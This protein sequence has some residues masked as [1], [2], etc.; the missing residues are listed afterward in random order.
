MSRDSLSQI[1]FPGLRMKFHVQI[2]VQ[3]LQTLQEV[4][5]SPPRRKRSMRSLRFI[6]LD[7]TI[8]LLAE[9]TVVDRTDSGETRA[10]QA[11]FMYLSHQVKIK[12]HFFCNVILNLEFNSISLFSLFFI[13]HVCSSLWYE[14]TSLMTAVL[15]WLPRL[16]WRRLISR[17]AQ[18]PSSSDYSDYQSPC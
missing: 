17:L 1:M 10:S 15:K 13:S 2:I 7:D 9:S 4:W 12:F 11:V 14:Q 3:S 18:S 5:D 6:K 8:C 16:N